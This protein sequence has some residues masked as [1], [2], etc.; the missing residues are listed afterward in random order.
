MVGNYTP[1]AS[2]ARQMPGVGSLRQ[3]LNSTVGLPIQ[4]QLNDT[5]QKLP[6]PSREAALVGIH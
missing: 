3:Q 2:P 4:L 6:A 5:P 1:G